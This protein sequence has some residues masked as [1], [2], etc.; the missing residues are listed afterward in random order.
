MDAARLLNAVN[1]MGAADVIKITLTGQGDASAATG[2]AFLS[3]SRGADISMQDLPA[4]PAGKVYQLWLIPKGQTTP[5][6][7]GVFTA[8]ANG[9]ASLQMPMPAGMPLPQIVAV[10]VEDGPTGVVQSA[11]RPVISGAAGQ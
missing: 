11:N 4:L 8:A 9:T 5:V 2:H 6:S 1:V 3:A 10:T 7:G